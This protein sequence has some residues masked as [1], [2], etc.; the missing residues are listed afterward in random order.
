MADDEKK[1]RLTA[2]DDTARAITSAGKNFDKLHKDIQKQYIQTEHGALIS[3][4][5]IASLAKEAGSTYDA[6]LKRVL[7]TSVALHQQGA[8]GQAAGAGV[9]A[10]GKTGAAA[11]AAAGSRIPPIITGLA[12]MAVKAGAVGIALET[13]RRGFMN[14]AEFDKKLRLVQNQTGLSRKQIDGL[15]EDMRHLAGVTGETKEELLEAFEELR[16]AGGF[17]PEETKKM[18]PDFAVAAQGAGAS[19][20]LF[21]RAAGDLMRN[22]KIP[23]EQGK[24][25]MEALSHA[26]KE[27]NLD[28]SK[29]GPNLSKMTA[30]G[31]AW[32]YEG[33][34]GMQR[35][36]TITGVVKEATG[37]A[38]K[39]GTAVTNILENLGGEELGKALGYATGTFYK[40]L[41]RVQEFG[42]EMG[43]KDV[44]GY[45]TRKINDAKD[46]HAVMK[47]LGIENL[48]QWN[49]LR[50]S[51]GTVGDK[52]RG[53]QQASGAVER[54]MNVTEGPAQAVARL[55]A[56]LDALTESLGAFLDAIGVSYVLKEFAEDLNNMA[57]GARRLVDLFNWLK[58]GGQKPDWVKSFTEHSFNLQV[59]KDK[60]GKPLMKYDEY[61]L[62]GDV[63]LQKAYDEY[64]RKERAQAAKKKKEDAASEER[65]AKARREELRKKGYTVPEPGPTGPKPLPA[66]PFTP[67]GFNKLEGPVRQ[68]FNVPSE[69][70]DR[71]IRDTEQK[72][73]KLGVVMQDATRQLAAFT[74]VIPDQDKARI[75]RTNL[76]TL[77]GGGWDRLPMSQNIED[78]RGEGPTSLHGTPTGVGTIEATRA[79]SA[80]GGGADGG[81]RYGG[82][83]DARVLKASYVPGGGVEGHVYGGPGAVGGGQGPQYAPASGRAGPP[84]S[85][86][87]G[88]GGGTTLAPP[89]SGTH[90]PR[91][92]APAGPGGNAPASGKIGERIATAKAAMEDQLRK[93]GVPEGNIKEAA[94]LLAGQALTESKLI[95]ST[96]HDKGTG[97]GIY[98]ARDDPRARGPGRRTKMFQWL[99]AHG[100]SR[101]SL[102]GQ[103]RYMAHEAMQYRRTKQALMTADKANRAQN[104][105]TITK[106]FEGP[107][108]Q[109]PGQ[110]AD[111]RAWTGT[112]ESVQAGKPPELGPTPTGPSPAEAKAADASIAPGEGG[113]VEEAQGR[114]AG[115]RKGKLDP[116]LREALE[117]AAEA[118]GVRVRVT[119]G[120]QRMHGAEGATG[121]HRHDKGRAAD[122]D[123]IDP[124]TGKVLA[125]DDPR[126]LKFLEESAAAG[127]GGT[128]TRY[129]DDPAKI[130]AGITGAGA[131]VGKGLGAYAGPAHERE[132][133]ARGLR[134]R[135]TPEQVTAA[136][137]A[138]IEARAKRDQPAVAAAPAPTTGSEAS[139]RRLQPGEE[140]YLKQEEAADK[141]DPGRRPRQ[142]GEEGYLRSLP[143][144]DRQMNVNLRVND[145]H[146]QFARTSMRRQADREVREAR[147][148]SYTE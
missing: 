136:R 112:A 106:E 66:S 17:T 142:P 54:G 20:K 67:E 92:G 9:A 140:G 25:V 26:S 24:Y 76:S 146:V 122:L 111:R 101:D 3:K 28:V 110:M 109:G 93:E 38:S 60:M 34:T 99:E 125:L 124:K 104:V 56:A 35:L 84:G 127:A 55:S 95:P 21:N 79:V 131:E 69:E 13:M 77:P 75:I 130:H 108:D 86:G 132:A 96:V 83:G 50:E 80:D 94:N 121:S 33:V 61:Q 14:F 97:Y 48:A 144:Q 41:K 72:A 107:Q 105:E 114:V 128:G 102:E 4:K 135:M 31:A 89:G 148:N 123:V 22:L 64:D 7:A 116:Q 129:M 126:R 118:S 57:R 5:A 90:A 74:E 2:E 63:A 23:A 43:N 68:R 100:Y 44:I 103:S 59:R 120:G 19:S 51:L 6:T 137:K 91:V 40:D 47:V 16:E 8:A 37:S 141:A 58:P 36:L 1:I 62:G 119:S 18:F 81:T 15:A 87:S 29:I 52:L 143:D 82:S 27:Y 73:Q 65:E 12:I 45:V 42:D 98:G 115:I 133:V 139:T 134:R 147:W 113:G 11:L 70:D 30:A 71:V 46:Q 117:Y 53:I 78:R 32:G 85:R 88:F 10:G 138:Q 145:S 49:K 39:A